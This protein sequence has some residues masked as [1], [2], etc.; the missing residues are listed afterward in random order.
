MYAFNPPHPSYGQSANFEAPG[1]RMI[2]AA[3]TLYFAYGSNLHIAQMA[4]RCPGSVFKGKATLDSYRW[5]IN[6]RGVANVVESGSDH[7]VEGLLYM[8]GPKDERTL[9]RSEGVSKGFYQKH[10]LRVSFEPHQR[11]SNF[12]TVRLS[13]L[14]EQSYD[15]VD[16]HVFQS[17]NDPN[18][19]GRF[20]AQR[21]GD[22]DFFSI[23]DEAS[24]HHFRTQEVKALVYVSED[25][26]TDGPIRE[27][28]IARMQ[29]AVNDAATLGVSKSFL[30]KYIVPFLDPAQ[31]WHLSAKHAVGDRH[32]RLRELPDPESAPSEPE[33][34]ALVGAETGLIAEDKKE[35]EVE[36]KDAE[37]SDSATGEKLS[38]VEMKDETNG[39]VD[40]DIK[41]PGRV[42]VSEL[43]AENRDPSSGPSVLFPDEMLVAIDKVEDS[44][45]CDAVG[46]IYIVVIAQKNSEANSGFSIA[47]AAKEVR[48]ANELAMKEFRDICVLNT[49]PVVEEG[50]EPDVVVVKE[51]DPGKLHWSLEKDAYLHL[52]IA[53]PGEEPWLLAWVE[54]QLLMKCM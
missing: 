9:D 25:Y 26:I 52:S 1:S 46:N 10:L 8:I 28:Y 2:R 45:T 17:N 22:F 29:H 7:S 33:S 30:N 24:K 44:T 31:I 35:P 32:E 20:A 12:K 34:Q 53:K 50:E 5:Q 42:D 38:D 51:G 13:H 23:H 48:L 4:Q 19:Q 39:E 27:E 49:K 43:K 18:Q 37:T 6:E 15:S 40:E 21:R 14:L 41:L 16:G 36:G 54:P 11:Y 3:S 47:A